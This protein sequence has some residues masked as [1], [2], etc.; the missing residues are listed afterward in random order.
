MKFKS[1]FSDDFVCLDTDI[2]AS[3]V[4]R[5]FV[6]AAL[7]DL[8]IHQMTNSLKIRDIDASTHEFR[9][10]IDIPIYISSKNESNKM[11][12]IKREMHIVENLKAKMLIET[13]I[14]KSEDIIL[15][16]SNK[17]TKIDSCESMKI[18]LKI[19]QRDSFVRRI[20]ISSFVEI[21]SSKER[22]KIKIA[23][24]KALLKDRNFIF[25]SA[26]NVDVSLYVH[27]IDAYIIEILVQNDFAYP[28][29]ISR[30][31]RLDFVRKI[32]YENCFHASSNSHLVLKTSKKN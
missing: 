18:A 1:N 10:Y 13:N 25:E 30:N 20:I 32:E 16:V 19:H 6:L 24:T 29:N 2:E 27:L 14:L 26:A 28:V 4:D 17:L 15:N 5:E 3:L 8:H 22:T 21:I 31:T 12:C 11:T 9:E 23:M 7:S